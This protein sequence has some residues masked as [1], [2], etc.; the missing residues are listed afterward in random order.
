MVHIGKFL[1]HIL[2]LVTQDEN[3]QATISFEFSGV[4][5]SSTNELDERWLLKML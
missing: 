3:N 5:N 4:V 2:I 1:E